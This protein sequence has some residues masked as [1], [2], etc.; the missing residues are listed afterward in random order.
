MVPILPL[1]LVLLAPLSAHLFSKKPFGWR[2][3]GF[4]TVN[5]VFLALIAVTPTQN[6]VIAL[7]RYLGERPSVRYLWAVRETIKV[8]PVA[9]SREEPA[10]LHR[11][12]LIPLRAAET[13]GC[14][15][16]V[17]VGE[18][19]LPSTTG[20]LDG[21][22]EVAVFEP[23]VL[24]RILVAANPEQNARRG[25]V[26]LFMKEGCGDPQPEPVP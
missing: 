19:Y 10:A 16:A 26:H 22:V 2:S 15:T 18:R 14:D 1:F 12:S 11:L 25:P 21:F 5:V 7:V 23:G 17:A 13:R 4:V 20:M 6:N 9:Y 8:Y 24:E 3:A